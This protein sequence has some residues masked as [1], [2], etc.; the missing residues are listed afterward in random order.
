MLF[1]GFVAGP[2]W[3]EVPVIRAPTSTETPAPNRYAVPAR[4]QD[5]PTEL[6]HLRT[7]LAAEERLPLQNGCESLVW[8]HAKRPERG[9]IL[10]LHG[11]S[12]G[13]WQFD[14]LG[15]MLHAA[16]FNVYA[17]RLVGHGFKRPDGEEDATKLLLSRDWTRY[18]DYSEAVYQ[19]VV[20]LGGPFSMMGISGGADVGLAVLENHPEFG[21]A[22]MVAPFLAAKN[23]FAAFGIGLVRGL[24]AMTGTWGGWWLDGMD[25]SWGEEFRPKARAWGR[26]GHWDMKAGNTYALLQFGQHVLG[27]ADRIPTP[28]QIVST[29]D[30][31][32]AA[33]PEI[34]ELHR[35]TGG[36]AR[37][38]HYHFPSEE[39]VPHPM[40]HFRENANQQ[41]LEKV[42]EII[43]DHLVS[44]KRFE[45]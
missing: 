5:L 16:G 13:T 10:L 30:D 19:Q 20:E 9:T 33:E 37:N 2:V 36:T 25:F 7:A 4:A 43:R 8:R 1:F 3:A 40:I 21:R 12:A 14:T 35:R 38:A 34:R 17:P 27:R 23:G 44:G 31:D 42:T 24:D 41:S 28:M 32:V 6:V 15:P 29:G 18:H 11:F 45:R 22:V 26:P 39:H